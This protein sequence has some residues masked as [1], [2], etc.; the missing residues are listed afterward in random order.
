M[1][2]SIFSVMAKKEARREDDSIVLKLIAQ[3][4]F[5]DQTAVVAQFSW[6]PSRVNL[7]R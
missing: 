6:N 5:S 7:R 1:I 2:I 4:N 3:E